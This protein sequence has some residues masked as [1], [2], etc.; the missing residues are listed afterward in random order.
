MLIREGEGRIIV[1]LDGMDLHEAVRVTEKVAGKPGIWGVKANALLAE[2]GMRALE[3]LHA[4]AEVRVFADLKLHDIPETV[5]NWVTRYANCQGDVISV[6][7][8]GGPAMVSRAV[9]A[10]ADGCGVLAVTVLTSLD[11]EICESVF[12]TQPKG[13]VLRLCHLIADTGISGIVCSAHEVAELKKLF[14]K[15]AMRVVP[16]IR[17]LWFQELGDQK[18]VATPR[19]AILAGATHLVMGR[20]ILK[21]DVAEN[22]KRTWDE[23]ADF[24]A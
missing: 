3:T 8:S 4:V 17:P 19:D 16:G 15:F 14:P 11:T 6:H 9:K 20:P 12:N 5:E 21:G 22:I 23:I 1:A 2:G 13:T 18:R 10:A 7:A 24:A